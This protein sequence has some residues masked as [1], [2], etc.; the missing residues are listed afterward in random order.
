[1]GAGRR[2][3]LSCVLCW[4]S[5]LVLSQSPSM[6][7]ILPHSRQSLYRA[8]LWPFAV[9]MKLPLGRHRVVQGVVSGGFPAHVYTISN[10]LI[11]ECAARVARRTKSNDSREALWGQWEV[12]GSKPPSVRSILRPGRLTRTRQHLS[13]L[14]QSLLQSLRSRLGNEERPY[15]SRTETTKMQ[16]QT[17]PIDTS[18]FTSN[19]TENVII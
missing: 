1:M 15:K 14:T 12:G 6:R 18:T 5:H 19:T 4:L 17:R 3:Y 11:R 13:Q 8:R 2:Y 9:K 7:T 16:E 10:Q